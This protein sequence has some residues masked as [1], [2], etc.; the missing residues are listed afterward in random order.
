MQDSDKKREKINS[1][2]EAYKVYAKSA[3][4]K[5]RIGLDY[6]ESV[7]KDELLKLPTLKKYFS[8]YKISPEEY[9]LK[10]KDVKKIKQL[11]INPEKLLDISVEAIEY[12]TCRIH[13]SYILKKA[14]NE[15]S[16]SEEDE[17]EFTSELKKLGIKLIAKRDKKKNQENSNSKKPTFG[18]L[19]ETKDI[20]CY[21]L[22]KHFNKINNVLKRNP[23][24]PVPYSLTDDIIADFCQA[25]FT[26]KSK[27]NLD[28][29]LDEEL[30][31]TPQQ[32]ECI[33]RNFKKLIEISEIKKELED[34]FHNQFEDFE[35]MNKMD[36]ILKYKDVISPKGKVWEETLGAYEY[37]CKINS[38]NEA[39]ET[40]RQLRQG[41]LSATY[42]KTEPRENLPK[43]N[44]S[45]EQSYAPDLDEIYSNQ[46]EELADDFEESIITELKIENPEIESQ[47]AEIE[48]LIQKIDP[49]PLSQFNINLHE[50]LRQCIEEQKNNHSSSKLKIF[51]AETLRANYWNEKHS[52]RT[53]YTKYR[54]SCRNMPLYSETSFND[55]IEYVYKKLKD[56]PVSKSDN[57]KLLNRII[58]T[59]KCEKL[60]NEKLRKKFSGKNEQKMNEKLGKQL[61]FLKDAVNSHDIRHTSDYTVLTDYIDGY[62]EP[63]YKEY[64]GLFKD[65]PDNAKP[66]KAFFSSRIH[67]ISEEVKQ[68]MEKLKK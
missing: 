56:K 15:L 24:D 46:N 10:L 41:E 66:R 54:Q 17:A 25:I 47:I 11:S 42:D 23:K 52:W 48:E 27:K 51:F 68:E 40:A 32:T 16:Y 33:N 29:E 53:L 59:A 9:F 39:L 57:P 2:Y 26:K 63:G 45:N 3:Y 22:G 13:N 67:S 43:E 61:K 28:D 19:F 31:F 65:L 38:K 50:E 12:E 7:E 14:L 18:E 58:N 49:D 5:F 8:L 44:D 30:P 1:P 20:S 34:S 60:I 4:S 21:S 37:F 64:W 36:A 62:A 55:V 35:T 6:I